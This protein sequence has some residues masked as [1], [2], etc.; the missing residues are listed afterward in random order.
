MVKV[1]QLQQKQQIIKVSTVKFD[2]KLGTGLKKDKDGNIG[3][4][5]GNIN[6]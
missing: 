1:Q 2:V 3:V 5:A 6:K 4:D